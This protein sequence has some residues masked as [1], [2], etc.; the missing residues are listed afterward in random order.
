MRRAGGI[1]NV[2]FEKAKAPRSIIRYCILLRKFKIRDSE[3]IPLKQKFPNSSLTWFWE[4]RLKSQVS[5]IPARW[6][7]NEIYRD[8][9]DNVPAIPSRLFRYWDKNLRVDF[10][11]F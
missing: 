10:A 8:M 9:L 5:L 4:F 6:F 2:G 3:L 7:H 11:G 1:F